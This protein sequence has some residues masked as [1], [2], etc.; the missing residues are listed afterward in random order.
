MLCYRLWM[1]QE[2]IQE[3]KA[4]HAILVALYH[5]RN[6]SALRLRLAL[7]AMLVIDKLLVQFIRA[8][9][10]CELLMAGW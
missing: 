9:V 4:K 10:Q 6:H 1:L 2:N 3:V 5:T 7:P 8:A